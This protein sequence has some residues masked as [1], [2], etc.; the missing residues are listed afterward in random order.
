MTSKQPEIDPKRA[1]I[2]NCEISPEESRSRG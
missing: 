2:P 1:L